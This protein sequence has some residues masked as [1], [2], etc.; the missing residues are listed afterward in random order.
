MMDLVYINSYS[1]ILDLK[2]MLM[3]IKILFLPESTEGVAEGN[4]LAN[5][6]NPLKPQGQQTT[7]HKEED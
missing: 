2:L 5:E 6:Q 4:L 7:E 3:T 1:L